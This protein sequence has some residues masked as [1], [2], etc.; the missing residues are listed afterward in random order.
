VLGACLV[1]AALFVAAPAHPEEAPEALNLLTWEG[2]TAPEITTAF[3]AQTGCTVNAVFVG[4]DY[5]FPVRLAGGG[6]LDFDLVSPSLDMTSVL[7][8]L[9]VIEPINSSWLAH[10]RDLPEAFREHPGVAD[11]TSVFAVPFDWGAFGLLYRTDKV[12][13]PPA[14][15]EAL[16]DE[17][18]AGRIALWDDESSLYTAARLVFGATSDV[19]TLSDG[20]LQDIQDTLIAQ[21]PLL[22]DYWSSA[23]ELVNLFVY[24]D[25]WLSDGWEIVARGLQADGLPVALAAPAGTTSG[26]ADAWQIVRESERVDC[27]YAWLNFATSPEGQCLTFQVTGFAPVNPK[28]FATCPEAQKSGSIDD[29]ENLSRVDLWREP[30]RPGRYTEVWNAVKAAQ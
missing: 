19:Y 29:P 1:G 13:E 20:E 10:W 24:G 12:N 21:K 2:Y 6:Y 28:A 30:E 7:V 3:T 25:V 14:S 16:W 17:R 18:Y 5:D 4:A 26:F 22:R 15:F 27:A 9:G 11:G 23:G 8:K